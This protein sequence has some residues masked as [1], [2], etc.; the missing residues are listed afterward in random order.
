VK[1]LKP[2][3]AHLPFGV[4]PYRRQPRGLRKLSLQRLSGPRC[5]DSACFRPP[6]CREVELDRVNEKLLCL[7]PKDPS[8]IRRIEAGFV[9]AAHRPVRAR[10]IETKPVRKVTHGDR[11]GRA[12]QLQQH[13]HVLSLQHGTNC[14]M[15]RYMKQASQSLV[16]WRLWLAPVE[17]APIAAAL[18]SEIEPDCLTETRPGTWSGSIFGPT[19]TGKVRTLGLPCFL[20]AMLT[21]HLEAIPVDPDA[22]VFTSSQGGPLRHGNFYRRHFKPVVRGRCP[23]RSTGSASTTLRHTCAA[24]LIATDAHPKAIQDHLGHRDIQTTFNVYGHL[25]PATQEA[26][27][28]ALD[29]AYSGSGQPNN[30]RTLR[31]SPDISL[32]SCQGRIPHIEGGKRQGVVASHIVA[33]VTKVPAA[34]SSQMPA[35]GAAVQAS[36]LQHGRPGSSSGHGC[37][38]R[39][40]KKGDLLKR[41]D[42]QIHSGRFR[43]TFLK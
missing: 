6:S 31:R 11:L 22:L 27:A 10:D 17:R 21:D 19:K 12:K 4:R 41:C 16:K 34:P 42:R 25:L 23:P 8:T 40:A 20:V 33:F 36:G 2:E 30:V 15:F 26:L 1:R 38:Q 9:K 37:E 18:E 7:R 28:A 43:P 13:N 5:R 35:I 32:E 3:A 29:S 14:S 39:A 24:L